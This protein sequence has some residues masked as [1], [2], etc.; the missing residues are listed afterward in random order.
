MRTIDDVAH[1]VHQVHDLEVKNNYDNDDD[2]DDGDGDDE[3]L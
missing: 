2:D 1:R 3:T